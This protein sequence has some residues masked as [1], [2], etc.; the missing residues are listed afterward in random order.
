L[1]LPIIAYTF[2]STKLEVRAKQFLP[3]IEGVEE[4]E[5]RYSGW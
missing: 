2:S 1:L 5:R 3:G 4:T